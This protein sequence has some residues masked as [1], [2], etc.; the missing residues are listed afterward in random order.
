[1]LAVRSAVL[2]PSV[3]SIATENLVCSK[4][5]WL[6]QQN[7]RNALIRKSSA[8][9]NEKVGQDPLGGRGLARSARIRSE[10]KEGILMFQ[11]LRE[12]IIS[13][14]GRDPAAHSYWKILTCH[15]GIHAPNFHRFAHWL[16]AKRLRHDM[17][18]SSFCAALPP[19]T[20]WIPTSW[21]GS[22]IPGRS[23]RHLPQR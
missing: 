18:S 8:L 9:L 12:D 11:S 19:P 6:C 1:M 21:P 15:P 14:F 2:R 7:G 3:R 4:R 17:I 20:D 10:N 23:G 5:G 13:V 16:W 22:G